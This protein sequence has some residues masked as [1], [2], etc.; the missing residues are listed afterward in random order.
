M[1]SETVNVADTSPPTVDVAF[2]DRRTAHPI[3][4]ISRNRVHFVTTNFNVTDVC[5]PDPQSEGI[6]TAFEVENGDT[7]KIQ[8]LKNTIQ[9]ETSTLELSV[10]GTDASGNAS[11]E[12]ALLSI[13]D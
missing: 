7:I 2:F 3:S 1:H 4:V 9:L 8:G 6:V 13:S 5:D 10:T 11:T 12:K